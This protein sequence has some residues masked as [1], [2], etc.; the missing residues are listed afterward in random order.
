MPSSTV[1]LNKA[2]LLVLKKL[3]GQTGLPM[4]VILANAIEA[5]KRKLFFDHLNHS[6]KALKENPKKWKEELAER[7]LLDNALSDGLDNE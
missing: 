7:A 3:A 4:Q 1:R 2:S 6:F 5:Y